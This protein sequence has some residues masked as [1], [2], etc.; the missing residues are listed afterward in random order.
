MS[1]HGMQENQPNTLKKRAT[2]FIVSFLAPYLTCGERHAISG[3]GHQDKNGTAR[4]PSLPGKRTLTKMAILGGQLG[5][6]PLTFLALHFEVA[7]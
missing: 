5:D 3:T 6:L 2:M 4:R 7:D 1:F